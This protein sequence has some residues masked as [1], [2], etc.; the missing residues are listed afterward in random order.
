ML[1]LVGLTNLACSLGLERIDWRPAEVPAERISKLKNWR[2]A[3]YAAW[4]AGKSKHAPTIS[5]SKQRQVIEVPERTQ[6]TYTTTEPSIRTERNFGIEN[7]LATWEVLANEILFGRGHGFRWF[8]GRLARQLPNTYHVSFDLSPRGMCRKV[9]K[10]LRAGLFELPQ[11]SCLLQQADSRRNCRLF[12]ITVKGAQKVVR[13]YSREV[14][15]GMPV[16]WDTSP[17][18]VFGRVG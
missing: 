14:P 18:E 10:Q 17:S 6:R 11:S 5:R 3:S 16:A 9:A 4:L 13:R 15:N 1:R 7:R 8:D 2:A 12:F